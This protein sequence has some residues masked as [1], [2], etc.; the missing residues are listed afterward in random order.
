MWPSMLAVPWVLSW[1][2]QLEHLHDA[3]PHLH[4]LG[5]PTAWRL[6]S[7]RKSPER[8]SLGSH[9]VTLLPLS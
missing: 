8:E 7:K 2:C 5:L 3:S 4:H 6:V 1:G 9:T